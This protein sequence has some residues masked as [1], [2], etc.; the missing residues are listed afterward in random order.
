[1]ANSRPEAAGGAIAQ[2]GQFQPEQLQ[3]AALGNLSLADIRQSM[4]RQEQQYVDAA[5]S[6]GAGT[7]DFVLTNGTAVHVDRDKAGQITHVAAT[8]PGGRHAAEVMT[9]DRGYHEYDLDAK[10]GKVTGGESVGMDGS[11]I[12]L[13][14]DKSVRVSTANDGIVSDTWVKYNQSGTKGVKE[15]MGFEIIMDPR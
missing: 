4:A 10:T 15:Q 13:G 11:G 5:K 6:L 7:P 2:P 14:K 1:M 9:P 3:R 12:L 8:E